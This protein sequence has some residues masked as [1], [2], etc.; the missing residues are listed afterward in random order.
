V[1]KHAHAMGL[2][3]WVYTVNDPQ[4]AEQ[5]RQWGIDGIITDEVQSFSAAMR[6]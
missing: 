6:A 4:R 3:A 1:I 2:R 5:L